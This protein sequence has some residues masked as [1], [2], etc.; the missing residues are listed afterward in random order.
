MLRL[1]RFALSLLLAAPAAVALGGCKQ[2]VNDRCQLSS[3][4][5]SV[6]VNGMSVDLICVIRP[7]V[8]LAEGGTCQVPGTE[9]GDAG[10]DDSGAPIDMAASSAEDLAS[11]PDLAAAPDLTSAATDGAPGG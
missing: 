6:M 10:T 5:G 9:L 8:S 1:R 2:G 3:D 4:C 7:G 11:S